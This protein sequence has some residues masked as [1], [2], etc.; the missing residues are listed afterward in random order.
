MTLCIVGIGG[1][2][3]EVAR[4]FLESQDIGKPLGDYVSFGLSK[5]MWLE[6][7]DKDIV[8]HKN[9]FYFDFKDTQNIYRP[10]V[11]STKPKN[12]SDLVKA[13]GFDTNQD[14]F[15]REAHIPK[16]VYEI[17]PSILEP[18]W[19]D[20]I[21]PY[22][23]AAIGEKDLCDGVLFI[24]SLGGGTGTGVINPLTTYIRKDLPAYPIFVIGVLTQKG[25]DDHQKIDEDR[26]DLA[27]AIAMH[28]L[29]MKND[30]IDCLMLVDNEKWMQ[31]NPGL[32][33][34]EIYPK[35]D[36]DI[37]EAMKPLLAARHYPNENA[38]CM[39][40]KDFFI[41]NYLDRKHPQRPIIVP[42]F[43]SGKRRKGGDLVEDALK[44]G[45]FFECDH[46]LAD[47]AIIF[48]RGFID[49]D[50]LRDMRSVF[51]GEVPNLESQGNKG[52]IIWRKMGDSGGNEVLILL[53]NPYGSK[54]AYKTPGSLEYRIHQV[55]EM[56]LGYMNTDILRKHTELR[57]EA[58]KALDNYFYGQDMLKDSLMKALTNL[59]KGEKYIFDKEL[60]IFDTKGKE[61]LQSRVSK[62]ID[63]SED[64]KMRQIAREVFRE[65]QAKAPRGRDIGTV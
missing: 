60:H 61:R 36:K 6:A 40:I 50:D 10:F 18:V 54:D 23:T 31:E 24:V 16:A 47:G 57:P 58:I 45:K 53:R 63:V 42:C 32:K 34:H 51:F 65:E 46:R 2:G 11:F 17:D 3:R 28:D 5:G 27:A 30:G 44:N 21:K 38:P 49:K 55:V 56:A 20:A 39:A 19:H 25:F 62:S 12:E 13:Q 1:C 8:E 48:A 9:K 43:S 4:N 14:G 15:V 59:E 33:I 64:D 29:L 37:F 7:D 26:R 41:S 35:I 52:L 22:T